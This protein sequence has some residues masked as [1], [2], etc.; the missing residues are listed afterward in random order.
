MSA[1]RDVN[2]QITQTISAKM[3]PFEF[4]MRASAETAQNVARYMKNLFR[5]LK[6]LLF[7]PIRS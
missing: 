4:Q 1:L 7:C 2:G 5:R 3:I 6:V